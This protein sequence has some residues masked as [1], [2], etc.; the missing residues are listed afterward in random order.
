MNK[1]KSENKGLKLDSKFEYL[2]RTFGR[3]TRNKDTECYV[4]NMLWQM[5]LEE[6]CE[7]QPVTQ[8]LVVGESGYYFLD[9][10]FPAVISSNS[11]R[12]S[13]TDLFL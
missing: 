8:Q 5:L 9:L 2:I 3:R 4:L 6:G 1:K 13:S 10:Y 7:I 12:F 11:L